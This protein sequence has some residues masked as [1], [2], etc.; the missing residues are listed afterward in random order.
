M[1]AVAATTGA[2]TLAVL[3]AVVVVG[4]RD[5]P[6]ERVRLRAAVE[7]DGAASSRLLVCGSSLKSLYCGSGAWLGTSGG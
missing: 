4:A 6:R 2:A 7:N 1:H 5:R 3:D